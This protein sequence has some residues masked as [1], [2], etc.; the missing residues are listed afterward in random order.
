MTENSAHSALRLMPI[1]WKRHSSLDQPAE[2]FC[3]PHWFGFVL[4]YFGGL[5]DELLS[6]G[7]SLTTKWSMVAG[8]E[9]VPVRAGIVTRFWGGCGVC[10]WLCLLQRLQHFRRRR[11]R[12]A[13]NP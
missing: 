1:V 4:Q 8:I 10:F 3:T 2:K 12:N 9:M 5:V 11:P 6:K 7:R 13:G